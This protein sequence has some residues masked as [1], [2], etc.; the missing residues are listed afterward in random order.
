MTADA[1]AGH[2]RV[3]EGRA[4]EAG[5]AFMAVFADVGR[6]HMVRIFAERRRAVV[7]AGA[8]SRYARMGECGIFKAGE[9]F[10]AILTHIR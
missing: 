7:A 1:I 4:F 5:E 2:A 6:L 3:G 10:M 8:I 9:A